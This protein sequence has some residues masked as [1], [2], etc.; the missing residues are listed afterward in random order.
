MQE[1]STMTVIQGQIVYFIT[2]VMIANEL[3]SH[4][5]ETSPPPTLQNIRPV[6]GSDDEI[7]WTI[8]KKQ[9]KTKSEKAEVNDDDN[10]DEDGDKDKGINYFTCSSKRGLFVKE[11]KLSR[12]TMTRVSNIRNDDVHN[13]NIGMV[14]DHCYCYGSKSTKG[15]WFFQCSKCEQV[16]LCL[17]CI[18]E[19]T[20]CR[21]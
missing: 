18:A 14:S 16:D 13:V 3:K 4:H 20:L 17:D 9:V 1:F 11:V 6:N 10:E 21:F 8:S 2:M 19:I 12:A 7:F 15:D 5:L